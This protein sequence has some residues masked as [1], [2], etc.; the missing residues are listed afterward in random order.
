MEIL[1]SLTLAVVILIGDCLAPAHFSLNVPHLSGP[2][3]KHFIVAA[4]NESENGRLSK[5][6]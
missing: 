1:V 3:P 4:L 6:L 5:H 2:K